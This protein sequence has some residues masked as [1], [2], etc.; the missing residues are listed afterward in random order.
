MAR[1]AVIFFEQEEILGWNSHLRI[2][3]KEA[4]NCKRISSENQSLARQV[5]QR[6][7]WPAALLLAGTLVM[8]VIDDF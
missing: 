4:W 6:A 7:N 8:L 5:T 2:R 1:Y 3:A